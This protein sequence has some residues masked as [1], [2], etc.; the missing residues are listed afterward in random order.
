MKNKKSIVSALVLAGLVSSVYAGIS[1]AAPTAAGAFASPEAKKVGMFGVSIGDGAE[2]EDICG[3]AIGSD[4]KALK[5]PSIKN[6]VAS[7]TAAE[8]GIGAIAIGGNSTAKGM[9][10]VTIGMSSKADGEFNTA[11]G[12]KATITGSTK[13]QS[14]SA[15]AIGNANITGGV[16]HI[17]RYGI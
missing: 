10:A 4:A 1:A 3:M 16:L 13:Y 11:V 12:T 7:T 6:G 14:D 15:I 8:K 5:G 17:S 9:G 2:S